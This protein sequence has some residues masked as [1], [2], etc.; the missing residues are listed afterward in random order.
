MAIYANPF[1]TYQP[2][3]RILSAI[4]NGFP[5]SFT[6]TFNHQYITNTI[7]RIDIPPGFGMQ[8]LNQQIGPITVTGPTTFTMPIDTT[9]YDTFSIPMYTLLPSG[10]TVSLQQAQVVPMA[11][12]NSIL[13]A[14][15][16]NV[17]PYSAT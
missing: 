11:E 17:L 12:D 2:S 16:Q 5:A 3:M 1:P 6:T 4:T 8:Q 10:I 9:N 13:T 7:V 15:V 14:A